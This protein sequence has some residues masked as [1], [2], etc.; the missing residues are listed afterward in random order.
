MAY[1]MFYVPIGTNYW[2]GVPYSAYSTPGYF[3]TNQVTPRADLL[4]AFNWDNGYPGKFVQGALDPNYL[5]TI[6]INVNPHMLDA[7]RMNQWNAGVEYGITDNTRV[8][9]NYVGSRGTRLHDGSLETYQPDASTYAKLLQSGRYS[10]VVTSAASAAAA[11]VPYPY[12]GFT[13]YAYMAISPFPQLAR[14]GTSLAHVGSP[15]G[16]SQYDSFQVEVVQ[17]LSHGIAANL[18]YSLDH[19]RSNSADINFAETGYLLGKIQNYSDLSYDANYIQPYNRSIFKGYVQW[20]LPLGKGRQFLSGSGKL[21][22]SLLSNWS[23]G[24]TIYLSTG[25]PLSIYS[26]NYYPGWNGRVFSNVAPGADLSRHFDGSQ[27]DLTNLANPVNRYFN[28]SGFSNPAFGSFG[29]SGPYIPGL[30]GFG[31]YNQNLSVIKSFK[32]KLIESAR[33]QLRA[34]FFN[35]FNRHSFGAPNTNISSPYF[36]QVTSVSSDC[37]RG[38]IGVRFEW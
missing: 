21:V 19:Y 35:I 13:G 8:S 29:N 7:G 36:G 31:T 10:A 32:I 37:R 4:P 22:E 12:P 17:R 26:T 23:L 9:F 24:T 1:S 11:G 34:E 25:T 18:S 16:I 14:L 28:P 15:Y 2:G 30:K 6:M 5:S 20:S 38:Q 3:P 33:L 27:L